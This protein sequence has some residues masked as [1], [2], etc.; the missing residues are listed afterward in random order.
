MSIYRRYL[1]IRLT[2][3]SSNC[4][5]IVYFTRAIPVER[6]SK[7]IAGSKHNQYEEN[8]NFRD[9]LKFLS[10]S[11]TVESWP[12]QVGVWKFE[13]TGER[14]LWDGL[15]GLTSVGPGKHAPQSRQRF[16]LII[17][18]WVHISRIFGHKTHGHFMPYMMRYLGSK[19][20]SW[21]VELFDIKNE[22][23]YTYIL[24]ALSY[25]WD[26]PS[27]ISIPCRQVGIYHFFPLKPVCQQSLL[28]C[29]SL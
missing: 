6:S 12:V 13:P 7:S 1:T 17:R 10:C 18:I 29:A 23:T 9:R 20:M 8:E 19:V 21:C 5:Y 22:S 16:P 27:F 26:E 3:S 25:S 11:S 14:K 28:R 24:Q 15:I 4:K 2:E